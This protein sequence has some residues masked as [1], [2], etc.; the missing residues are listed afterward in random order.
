MKVWQAFGGYQAIYGGLPPA[1]LVRRVRVWLAA[2]NEKEL[3]DEAE[4]RKQQEAWER[5]N[6]RARRDMDGARARG[7]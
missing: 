7:R 4:Q 2:L 1:Q 3:E 6:E 5:E